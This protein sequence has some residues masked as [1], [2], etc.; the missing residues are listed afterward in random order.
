MSDETTEVATEKTPAEI[1]KEQ[2]KQ[3]RIAALARARESKK[4]KVIV[5]EAAITKTET[6]IPK[7]DSK[8]IWFG[9]V[10]MNKKGVPSGDY[11]GWT[12]DQQIEE[13]GREISSIER[14]FDL[15]AYTGKDKV[16]MRELL[17][18][19]KDRYEA[20]V[21]S[22][23]KLGGKDKDAVY[24][25]FKDLGA[26][27]GE[28][29]FTYTEMHKQTADA[30]VE[31]DRMVKPCIEIKSELEA[32]FCKQR[33]IKIV[34]GKISRNHASQ[35]AQIFGKALG[36]GIIDMERFRNQR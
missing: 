35:M 20:I 36:E 17:K 22:K 10:D 14:G 25:S 30:H 21:S 28:S 4:K 26:R 15:D 19:R 31:A 32:D 7:T 34:D 33:G 29:M 5:A 27:I 1:K 9:E 3:N 16:K 11:P 2:A 6:V 12:F 8:I 24:A 18:Q 13:L 23:P